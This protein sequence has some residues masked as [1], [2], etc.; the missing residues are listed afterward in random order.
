MIVELLQQ[1]GL[2]KYEA[3]AYAALLATGPLTGYELGKR[4]AVPLSRSYEIL[5]RLVQKGLALVQPSD[6]PRYAAEDPGTFLARTRA[7][8]AATL[9]ALSAAFASLPRD[10]GGDDFWVVRGREPILAHARA[11]IAAA[12]QAVA[13]AA[14]A[15]AAL[16]DA[17]AE[18]RARGCQVRHAPG[19]AQQLALLADDRRALLGTL[20][21]EGTCQAVS[22]RNAALVGTVRVALRAPTGVPSAPVAAADDGAAADWL[23][24][25][26]RKQRRLLGLPDNEAA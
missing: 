22:G 11:M 1:L 9:D 5:E 2:S 21:P 23:G 6:P 12:R 15:G 20:A 14:P 7:A 10:D 25:E 26:S 13:L 19:D 16:A 3:E 18:A 24:W 4:S 17:L 8:Q